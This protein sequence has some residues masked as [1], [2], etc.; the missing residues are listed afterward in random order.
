MALGFYFHPEGMT[1]AKY[2]IVIQQLEAAGAG[3]P[4]GRLHHSCFGREDHVMVYD[5]WASQEEFDAFGEALM[6][7]LKDNGIDVGQPDVMPIHNMI[8]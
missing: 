2:D 5:I 7:I 6:P 1:T 4:K 8:Q 3:S